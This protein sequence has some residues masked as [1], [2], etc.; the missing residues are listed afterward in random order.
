MGGERLHGPTLLGLLIGLVG[1]AL[2]FSPA[3]HSIDA[4]TVKGCLILQL[5]C[6]CWNAGSLLQR[7]AKNATHPI[8]SG[9]IQQ[10][11][12]GLA[13]LIP[14]LLIPEHPI[15]WSTRGV[16]AMLYLVV[17][18]SLVGYSSYIYVLEKLPVAVVSIYTYVN[19][20]VAMILGWLIYAEPLGTR[21]WMA[22]AIIFAGVA[23]VKQFGQKH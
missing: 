1:A 7:R 11:A 20:V 23:I 19:P 6:F 21:E 14:A 9:A 8:V 3:G 15:V 10:L 2:L 16:S 22:M 12:A 18:G 17:F 5:G 13:F 4:N